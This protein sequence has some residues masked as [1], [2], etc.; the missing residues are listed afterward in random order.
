MLAVELTM[1]SFDF[2]L[3]RPLKRPP[4]I[5]GFRFLDASVS[6]GLVE[7]GAV[8]LDTFLAGSAASERTASWSEALIVSVE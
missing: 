2:A 5:D 1:V 4:N 8:A 6:C 3:Q 7:G